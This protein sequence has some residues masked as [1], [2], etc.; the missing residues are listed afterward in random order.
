M[1]GSGQESSGVKSKAMVTEGP[2]KTLGLT[3]DKW[4]RRASWEMQ[5]RGSTCAYG[6][7]TSKGILQLYWGHQEESA[8]RPWTANP[9]LTQETRDRTALAPP[10][11]QCGSRI[12]R[13]P[14]GRKNNNM[15]ISCYI[16]RVP[17]TALC[18]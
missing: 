13:W 7:V 6:K 9:D 17:V 5:R 16:S 18:F 10:T 1:R 3:Q 15:V 2:G 11:I 4:L 14:L 12:L 8:V